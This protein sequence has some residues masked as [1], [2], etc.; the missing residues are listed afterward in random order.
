[1]D[2][3]KRIFHFLIP[4]SLLIIFLFLG[5]SNSWALNNS[6]GEKVFSQHCSACHLKGGNIIRRS[7]NLK[8]KTLK[9]NA[10]DD[11]EAIAKVARKGIGIMSGYEKVLKEDEDKVVA[12]WILEQAQKAWVQG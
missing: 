9:R 10:L 2:L 5:D 11:P 6:T 12:I 4:L 7:K 1:M 8:I 3:L